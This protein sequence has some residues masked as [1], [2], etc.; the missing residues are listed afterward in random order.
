[1]GKVYKRKGEEFLCF[2]LT[3]DFLSI[4]A[5]PCKF[6]VGC[7]FILKCLPFTVLPATMISV[8]KTKPP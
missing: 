4:Y 8:A 7:S 6:K 1:M 2:V 3:V 5:W